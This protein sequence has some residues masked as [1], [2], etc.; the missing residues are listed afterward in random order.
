ML[1][2]LEVVTLDSHL[3]IERA[4]AAARRPLERHRQQPLAEAA[5]AAQGLYGKK[6][7]SQIQRTRL[8]KIMAG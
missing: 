3:E 5:A 6:G 1:G 2:G 7:F 4:Q 8:S